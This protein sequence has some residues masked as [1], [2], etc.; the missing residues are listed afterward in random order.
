MS[1]VKEQA[2]VEMNTLYSS[3]P[4]PDFPCLSYAV[5]RQMPCG[6][7]SQLDFAQ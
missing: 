7:A 6:V 3:P 2:E 1:V 5:A 4:Q